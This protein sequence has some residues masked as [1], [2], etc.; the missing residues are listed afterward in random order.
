MLGSHKRCIFKLGSM[1]RALENNREDLQLLL[2]LQIAILASHKSTERAISKNRGRLGELKRVLKVQRLPKLEALKLKASIKRCEAHL[3]RHKWL[4]SIWRAFGDGIAFLYLDKWAIKPLLYNIQDPNKKEHAGSILGKSGLK[5]ELKLLRTIIGSGI[6]A[7]LNDLTNCIR[8]GDI[9]LLTSNDPQLIE[10]KSSTNTNARTQRQIENIQS[11]H[12]Y[13]RTDQ[14]KNVRG[15]PHLQRTEL[16]RQETHYRDLLDASIDSALKIGH[17]MAEPE[18]GTRLI[19]T[20]SSSKETWD[21]VFS[22]FI[23]SAF[24][25]LNTLKN[26]NEWGVYFPYTLSIRSLDNLY[27]FLDGQ[28]FLVVAFDMVPLAIAARRRGFVLS[29]TADPTWPIQLDWL[30]KTHPE[31]AQARMSSHFLGRMACE[32]LSWKWAL[33]EERRRFLKFEREGLPSAFSMQEAASVKSL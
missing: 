22:G 2:R 9:C 7:L 5:N 6:P 23:P 30:R 21:K 10:V 20:T 18:A 29:Q 26:E 19:A 24:Y 27:A 14:A 4:L 32:L 16:S 25:I 33:S 13:H 8:H 11:I 17:V 1:L 3:D 31:P 28:V 15:V 12:D